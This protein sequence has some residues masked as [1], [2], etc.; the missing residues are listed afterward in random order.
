MRRTP[1]V[2]VA[3][4]LVGAGRAPEA[5]GQYPVDRSARLYVQA[6]YD[7]PGAPQVFEHLWNLG[8]TASVGFAYPVSDRL[9][10]R[11][12]FTVSRFGI[13]EDLAREYVYASV[14]RIAGGDYRPRT[15]NLDLLIFLAPA[16]TTLNL[17]GIA[18]GGYYSGRLEPVRPEGL[19]LITR[20]ADPVRNGFQARAGLGLQLRVSDRLTTFF[21]WNLDGGF[22]GESIILH[23]AGST[24]LAWSLGFGADGRTSDRSTDR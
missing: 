2:L 11:P 22:S 7:V 6:G 9:V 15:A 14:D 24:G 18:G 17:Y 8:V 20:W 1:I 10:L 5:E 3:C 12:G 21:E 13:N 23:A 4:L 19:D 16:S